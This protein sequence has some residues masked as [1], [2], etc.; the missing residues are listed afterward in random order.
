MAD[1]DSSNVVVQAH[2]LVIIEIRSIDKVSKLELKHCIE[3][4]N[5]K[6]ELKVHQYDKFASNLSGVVWFEYKL[7]YAR[8]SYSVISYPDICWSSEPKGQKKLSKFFERQQ[9]LRIKPKGQHLDGRLDAG[10]EPPCTNGMSNSLWLLRVSIS[11]DF[12]PLIENSDF[13]N[14]WMPLNHRPEGSC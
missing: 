3:S 14:D 12:E 6:C 11:I 13:A 10:E 4:S 1:V 7:R 2:Y 5:L 9:K 8:I